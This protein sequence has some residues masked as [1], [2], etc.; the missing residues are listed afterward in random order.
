MGFW[1][2]IQVWKWCKLCRMPNGQ[3]TYQS[4]SH[5][6]T[7]CMK[8]TVLT[9]H[10]VDT[11]C[12]F[13]FWVPSE[14]S[15]WHLSVCWTAGQPANSCPAPIHSA[16]HMNIWLKTNDS[17]PETSWSPDSAQCNRFL[18]LNIEMT[19]KEGKLMTS[20]RFN[21]ITGCSCQFSHNALH[22]MRPT[23]AQTLGLLN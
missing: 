18:Y 10:K 19:S 15:E 4:A 20:P 3:D 21:N 14:H 5:E 6:N 7:N 16:L 8:E 9:I 13:H 2:V 22:K 17:Q 11:C 1:M 12:K 23:L